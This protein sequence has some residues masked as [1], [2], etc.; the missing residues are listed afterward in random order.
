M[1]SSRLIACVPHSWL[2]PLLT[3]PIAVMKNEAGKWG[4]LDI[5]RLL[6][7]IRERMTKAANARIS[8]GERQRPLG[9]SQTA[10]RPLRE[11]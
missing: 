9:A 1:V 2:D 10:K 5:E 4:C 7:A 6:T 11:K 3:G 8:A